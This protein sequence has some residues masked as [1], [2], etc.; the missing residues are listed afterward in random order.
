MI[1]LIKFY[2]LIKNY[3]KYVNNIFKKEKEIEK[4]NVIFQ[5]TVLYK[6]KLC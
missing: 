1:S 3:S 4:N 2:F 5:T 6:Y